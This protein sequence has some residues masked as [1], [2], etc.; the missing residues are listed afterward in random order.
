MERLEKNLIYIT[1]A[2]MLVFTALLLYAGMG[3]GI[4]LPTSHQHLAPFTKGNV[5]PRENNRFEVYLIAKMWAFDPAEIVLPEKAKVDFYV[6]A[7]DVNHGIQV[8]GTNVNLMAVPGSVNVAHQ[9]F[10]EQGEYPVICH[11]YCG[12]NHQNMFGKIRVVA[13]EEYLRLIEE[14]A[15]RLTTQGE[16]LLAQKDCTACHTTDGTESIGPT[17]KGMFGRKTK[18]VDGHEITVDEGYL[19]EAIRYPD[20]QIVMDYEPGSMPETDV[21]DQEIRQMIDYIKTL[22]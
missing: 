13:P 22:K 17:L 15:K 1:L 2:L 21:T 9:T 12:L 7:L 4:A 18:L 11:E 10:D 8:V 3:L 5:L 20:R 16:A 19:F 6:S 14:Q